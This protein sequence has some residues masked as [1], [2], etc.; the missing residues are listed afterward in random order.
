M[1]FF[2]IYLKNRVLR[3]RKNKTELE[4]LYIDVESQVGSFTVEFIQS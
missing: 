2:Q 4:S 3:V 1:H